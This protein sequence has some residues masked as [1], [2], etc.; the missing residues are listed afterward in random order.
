MKKQTKLT[1]EQTAAIEK[2]AKSSRLGFTKTDLR[3]MSYDMMRS[4]QADLRRPQQEIL[5]QAWF[6]LH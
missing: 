5:V 6:A 4:I 1:A 2:V 3:R